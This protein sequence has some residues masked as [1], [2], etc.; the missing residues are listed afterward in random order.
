M[1]NLSAV[2]AKLDKQLD[3]KKRGNQSLQKV[4]G[5]VEGL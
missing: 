1:Q 3:D 2:D 4:D 5:I